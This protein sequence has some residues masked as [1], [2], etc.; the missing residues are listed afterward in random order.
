MWLCGCVVVGVGVVCGR[1]GVCGS[2]C[3]FFLQKEKVVFSFS[4]A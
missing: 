2:G 1:V 3:G 4:K